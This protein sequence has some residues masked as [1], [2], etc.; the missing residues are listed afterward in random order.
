MDDLSGMIILYLFYFGRPIIILAGLILGIV[1]ICTKDKITKLLGVSI[2]IGAVSS[3]LNSVYDVGLRFI[4]LETV[5]VFGYVRTFATIIFGF[6]SGIFL[7]LYAKKRYGT[8]LITGIILIIGGNTISTVF[9]VIFSKLFTVSDF[10][11]PSQ[12][13]YLTSIITLVPS[14]AIT[15]VWFIIFFKNRHKENEL[16]LLWIDKAIRVVSAAI[17]LGSN[18]CLF[19]AVGG[20]T[21]FAEINDIQVKDQLFQLNASLIFCILYLLMN[22][23]IVVKG[24]KA[25]EDKNAVVTEE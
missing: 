15:I 16:K 10:E 25:S 2:T 19:I 9:T 23:Y 13:S 17:S 22:I 24:R 7:Y 18:I 1:I 14:L 21:S 20:T 4:S 11:N 8:K 5:M 12:F 6:A 3:I